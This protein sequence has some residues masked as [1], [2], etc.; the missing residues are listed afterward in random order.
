M[1]E[2]INAIKCTIICQLICWGVFILCDENKYISQYLSYSCAETVAM[3]S[4]I[5]ILIVLLVFYFI[6]ANKYVKNNNMNSK[7]FNIILFFLWSA[8]SILIT[9]VL[10]SLVANNVLHVCQESGASC[11]LNGIEY[12]AEGF[13]MV[14]LAVLILIIKII[15]IFYKYITKN[16]KK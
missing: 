10:T 14:A 8:T 5:V 2:F 16:K 4:G 7:K 12:V 3:N 1:K 15:I 11:F 13:F 9:L 6:S